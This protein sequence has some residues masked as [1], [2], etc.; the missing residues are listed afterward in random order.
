MDHCIFSPNNNSHLFWPFPYIL[1]PS[2]RTKSL[3]TGSSSLTKSSKMTS[4]LLYPSHNFSKNFIT[5]F[6]GQCVHIYNLVSEIMTIAA[7]KLCTSF[8]VQII[9]FEYNIKWDANDLPEI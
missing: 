9:K 8:Y 6:L 1:V 3:L 4:I 7:A 5:L 2:T